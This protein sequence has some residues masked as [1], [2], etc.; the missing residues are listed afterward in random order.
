MEIGGIE[1]NI[2]I[3]D[4]YNLRPFIERFIKNRWPDF[5]VEKQDDSEWFFFK[6]KE[7]EQAW[8]LFGA[9]E[10]TQDTMI[11]FI[12]DEHSLSVIT[13]HEEFSETK[14]MALEL[15]QALYNNWCFFSN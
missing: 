12:F 15:E 14:R 13:H 8:N 4:S 5:Q 7:Q 11:H 2:V 3:S 6:N 10:Q 1:L 9:T